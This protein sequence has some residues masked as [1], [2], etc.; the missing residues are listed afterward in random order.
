[1]DL[2]HVYFKAMFK[3]HI[4]NEKHTFGQVEQITRN[5]NNA[6]FMKKIFANETSVNHIK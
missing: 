6:D 3:M 2:K 1:M 5:K 4:S